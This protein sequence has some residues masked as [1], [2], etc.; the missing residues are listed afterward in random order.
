MFSFD[1]RSALSCPAR[2]AVTPRHRRV[3]ATPSSH[4]FGRR[5]AGVRTGDEGIADT[6]LRRGVAATHRPA[7][8][9]GLIKLRTG[10]QRKACEKLFHRQTPAAF[11]LQFQNPQRALSAADD[12]AGFVGG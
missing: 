10:L 8:E 5:Q 3:A 6:F 12:D 11:A 4:F 7:A 9:F 2:V 1:S